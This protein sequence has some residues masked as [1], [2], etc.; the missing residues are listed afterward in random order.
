MRESLTYL[1]IPDMIT[2]IS[3]IIILRFEFMMKSN[4]IKIKI[5]IWKYFLIAKPF[6]GYEK[7]KFC[8]V[9]IISFLSL[10][11]SDCVG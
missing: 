4:E 8:N 11:F 3:V 6:Q 9:F 7:I 10:Y 1:L 5:F 2:A